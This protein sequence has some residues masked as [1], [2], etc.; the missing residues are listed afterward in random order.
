M[1]LNNFWAS[2]SLSEK[3]ELKQIIAAGE[4]TLTAVDRAAL[5]FSGM[6][7]DEY[8][9][10]K[11]T[12][13]DEPEDDTGTVAVPNDKLLITAID[14]GCISRKNLD[15]W[16]MQLSKDPAGTR[17]LIRQMLGTAPSSAAAP[18]ENGDFQLSE[19]DIAAMRFAGLT[20]S[21]YRRAASQVDMSES[22]ILQQQKGA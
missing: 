10:T 11:L 20:E 13:A 7:A 8:R 15:R 2:L 12:M 4:I 22:Q 3:T 21:E 14:R 18:S 1:N 17:D 5:K 9:A 6:S 19:E 16:T